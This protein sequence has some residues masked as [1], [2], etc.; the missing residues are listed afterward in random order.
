M[1]SGWWTYVLADH[2]NET[3]LRSL[4]GPHLSR[5]WLLLLRF[6][7]IGG[8][9]TESCLSSEIRPP[10]AGTRVVAL[11]QLFNTRKCGRYSCTLP[12]T[13]D[14]PGLEELPGLLV[15]YE[16]TNPP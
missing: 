13:A 7:G 6:K 1:D 12:S 16:T 2:R 4:S 5:L 14:G 10:W 8:A 15:L 3:R 11:T 9:A